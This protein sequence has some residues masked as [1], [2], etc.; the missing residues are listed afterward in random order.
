MASRQSLRNIGEEGFRLIDQTEERQGRQY[1]PIK[2]TVHYFHPPQV[3]IAHRADHMHPT[4]L[5]QNGYHVRVIPAPVANKEDNGCVMD[6][7]EAARR[8]GGMVMTE[9][10]PNKRIY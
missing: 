6:C 4:H 5:G 10:Y 2:P 8:Y 3:S 1:H 7:Y 9:F